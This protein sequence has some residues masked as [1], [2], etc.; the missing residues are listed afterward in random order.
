M[1][2]ITAAAREAA[3][4]YRLLHIPGGF[5]GFS[6]ACMRKVSAN[7]RKP[8]GNSIYHHEPAKTG[9]DQRE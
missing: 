5:R 4:N 2:R 7:D 6:A 8:P 1:A 9:W 3:A